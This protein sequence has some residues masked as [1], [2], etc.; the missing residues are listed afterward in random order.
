MENL[1]AQGTA[2]DIPAVL[3]NRDRRVATQAHLLTPGVGAVVAAKLNIP[4]P[5]KNNATIAAF[6]TRQLAAFEDQLLA[7]GISFLV[8]REWP[9]AATGPERFYQVFAPAPAVKALTTRFEES[10]PFRRLFDLDVLTRQ[11]GQVVGLSR[12]DANQPARTCLVCGR[13]AKECGRS[14]RHSVADLQAAVARMI[15][16]ASAAEE[17][18]ALVERLVTNGLR[19][20]TYE[21][22][23]WPKPGLVDPV[24]GA[25]HPDMDTFMFLDSSLALR[26]YLRQCGQAGLAAA[27]ARPQLLFKQIRR[28]GL[29]AERAMFTATKGVNTHKG[30]LFSL[31][32]LTCAYAACWASARPVTPAALQAQVKAMLVDLTAHDFKALKQK[33]G[34][35]T[36]GEQQ[37]LKYGLTGI[38]GE[39]RAG[40]PAVFEIGLPTLKAATGKTNERILTTFVALA[41]HTA[42]S[43]LVK[44]AG[45]PEILAEKT[46][47]FTKIAAAGGPATPAGRQ[48]LLETEADFSRRHLSMGGTADLLIVTLF[49]GMM[50]DM[51]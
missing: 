6:F 45:G 2:V 21:V 31:G 39:A 20:L 50:E 44:R 15:A 5:I 26:T 22:V 33:Q 13:P 25:A 36:A 48:L 40:Y 38:R 30:A 42:D 51:L 19:A 14:R 41:R 9:T 49:V 10:Q 12:A 8:A 29:A 4:G 46:A 32:V 37:F 27:S 7:A 23:T 28:F 24:E 18:A 35:L 11:E 16:A 43:T 47:R 1:F 17:E 3:E 34:P